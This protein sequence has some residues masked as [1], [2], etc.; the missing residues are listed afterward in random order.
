[1]RFLFSIVLLSI[2]LVANCQDLDNGL[3]AHY[4]FDDCQNL[5]KDESGN[6]TAAVIQG[7][8]E[9]VCGVVGNA[10]QLDGVGDYLLFLGTISNAF[11]TID[12][13]ISIYIKPTN[14]VGIQDIIS[15]KEACDG[16]RAFSISYASGS[17]FVRAQLSQDDMRNTQINAQ[18]DF[19][20]CWY[21]LVF[22]RRGNR[23]QLYVDGVLVQERTADSRVQ[24][25]NNEELSIANGECVGLTENRFAGLIDEFRVY[26]RALRLEEIEALYV[27]PDRIQNDAQVL[28]L[29]DA[30]DISVGQTCANSFSWTPSDGVDNPAEAE[31]SIAPTNAGT[32]TYQ[33]QLSD[34]FCTAEDTIRITVI[35]PEAL[36]CI[37]QLPKAFTPN[38]DGRNDEYGISNSTVL[39]DKLIEFEIFDRW[40][41][42]IFRTNSPFEKWDGT[43]N[44]QELNPG[45]LLYRV[46]YLCGEEEKTDMG[47]LTLLR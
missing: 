31:V 23:S 9:C 36:P 45:V 11:N 17:N 6:N 35:D 2:A 39:E 46:R 28:F 32:F 7:T 18:L 43:F 15:K 44:G 41:G 24:I 19:G 42:Q 38:G 34:E 16:N 21:H 25:D 40:G 10:L 20:R 33:L 14:A 26:D 4:S 22:V 5:G 27:Q 37:A 3:V 8:P 29:G 47:S 13:S 1:M 30:V 12:F